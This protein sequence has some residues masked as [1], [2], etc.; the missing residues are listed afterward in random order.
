VDEV[1][2]KR[3]K[4][5]WVPRMALARKGIVRK[6]SIQHHLD[7]AN[8]DTLLGAIARARSWMDDLIEGRVNSFRDIAIRENK[9]ERHIRRLVPL[10]FLSPRIVEAIANGAAPPHLTVTLLT[11]AL[12]HSWAGQ[13]NKLEMV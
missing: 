6:P 3:I 4:V 11:S 13:E 7:P 2:A 5:P 9:V 10:A 8:C 1:A 12:P